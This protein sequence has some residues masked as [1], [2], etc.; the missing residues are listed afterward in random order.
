MANK[1]GGETFAFADDPAPAEEKKQR[2]ED[3]LTW[4]EHW[5]QLERE[6]SQAEPKK[7][8]QVG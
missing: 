8:D 6:L 4:L 2:R 5:H 3:D 1:K 7:R